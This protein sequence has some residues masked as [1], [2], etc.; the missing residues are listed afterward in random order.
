MAVDV[1]SILAGKKRDVSL[2]GDDILFIP[3]STGKKAALRA[4][5]AAVQAGTGLVIWRAP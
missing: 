2:Q 1:K 4:V 3:G 5:E